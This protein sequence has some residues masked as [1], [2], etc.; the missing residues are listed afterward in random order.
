MSPRFRKTYQDAAIA[1]AEELEPED[2]ESPWSY[3]TASAAA[4]PGLALVVAAN[5]RRL[6]AR[7]GWTLEQLARASLVRRSALGQIELARLTPTINVVWRIARALDVPF[8]ALI[9]E[10]EAD[11]GAVVRARDARVLSSY[12]GALVSRPLF[13]VDE[14]RTTELYELRVAP[15]AREEADPHPTG[16]R[17]NL[18]VAEGALTIELDASTRYELAEGDAVL[19]DADRPHVYRNPGAR[20]TRAFLV[21]AYP[22]TPS[23]PRGGGR[24][25][26]EPSA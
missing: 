6:R 22:D 16:T 18:V 9:G 17:E 25:A 1:T 7:R 12:Q 11:D 23:R 10:R 2:G 3:E 26:P 8:S 5:L 24:R 13:P 20:P 19:F 4:S 15:G 21:L 14:P